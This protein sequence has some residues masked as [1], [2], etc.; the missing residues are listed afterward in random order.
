MVKVEEAKSRRKP[1]EKPEED[2]PHIRLDVA[3]DGN[4]TR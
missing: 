3:G 2:K 1:G 4:Q